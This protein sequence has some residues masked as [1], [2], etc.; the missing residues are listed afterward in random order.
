MGI[1]ARTILGHRFCITYKRDKRDHVEKGVQKLR[2]KAETICH[3]KGQAAADMLIENARE[4]LQRSGGAKQVGENLTLTKRRKGGLERGKQLR[5]DS[6]HQ[7][8]A[9]KARHKNTKRSAKP[10]ALTKRMKKA[11]ENPNL[12]ELRDFKTYLKMRQNASRKRVSPE[13]PPE[14]ES[15]LRGYVLKKFHFC[16]NFRVKDPTADTFCTKWNNIKQGRA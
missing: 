8:N 5:R 7:S 3:S 9:A 16:S 11:L 10:A 1:L 6:E 12:V 14:S 2:T 4:T 15:E 13:S